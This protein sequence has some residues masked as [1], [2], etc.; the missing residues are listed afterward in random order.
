MTYQQ[1][2][3]VV[4]QWEVMTSAVDI[5]QSIHWTRV[6]TL[7]N[8]M[9]PWT[10]EGTCTCGRGSDINA[11]WCWWVVNLK[12]DVTTHW[13]GSWLARPNKEGMKQVS[14]P[15][16][17][18]E[19]WACIYLPDAEYSHTHKEGPSPPIEGWFHTLHWRWWNTKINKKPKTNSQSMRTCSPK[20]GGWWLDN[21]QGIT[22]VT[23]MNSPQ[24]ITPQ[25]F[26]L[27]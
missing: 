19:G 20:D 3:P 17:Q 6:K 7:G 11:H 10:S 13:T 16:C 14:T 24:I 9:W 23:G 2:F 8:V 26:E 25:N 21:P 15:P 1:D 18:E 12:I 22:W 4:D 5:C 27:W